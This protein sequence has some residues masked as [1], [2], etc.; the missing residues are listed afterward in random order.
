MSIE[1]FCAD[2]SL[3]A[4]VVRADFKADG[5]AFFT[6]Q[7][8][9]QQLGYMNREAGYEVQPHFHKSLR[10][11]VHATQEVLF[12][13]TGSCQLD[14]YGNSKSV[15]VSTILRQGDVVLLADG[16]HGLVM[17]EQTE[18]IEVKQGPYA[19]DD[20]KVRFNPAET[21]S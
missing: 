21:T 8:S 5:I 11:E 18:I 4:L 20:D 7:D 17:L 10:K 2:D 13:R 14:L 1:R 16:G 12:I 19:G 3:L 15:R 9:S 6:E